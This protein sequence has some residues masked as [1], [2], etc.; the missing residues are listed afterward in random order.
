MDKGNA[1]GGV[2]K[3]GPDRHRFITRLFA[4]HES[5]GN[6]GRT[7][8]R[9]VLSRGPGGRK[10]RKTSGPIWTPYA[11]G[12]MVFSRGDPCT[13]PSYNRGPYNIVSPRQVTGILNS[14]AEDIG[15]C[16]LTGDPGGLVGLLNRLLG[17]APLGSNQVEEVIPTARIPQDFGAT[18]KYYFFR[19]VSRPMSPNI[20]WIVGCQQIA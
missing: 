2:S 1:K 17:E 19:F 10:L 8:P 15:T 7:S 11:K 13:L 18:S 6:P 9:H 20:S 16:T 3:N 14:C 4:L 12:H 5:D